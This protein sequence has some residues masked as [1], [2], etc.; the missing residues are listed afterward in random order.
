MFLKFLHVQNIKINQS[1]LCVSYDSTRKG[2]YYSIR[3]AKQ[4]SYYNKMEGVYCR[5]WPDYL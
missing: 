5:I 1:I 2:K 4:V 3:T